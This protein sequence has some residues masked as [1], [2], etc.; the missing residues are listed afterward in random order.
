MS[1]LILCMHA[2][3]CHHLS[4][5]FS[6][7]VPTDG[8][9]QTQ[10]GLFLITPKAYAGDNKGLDIFYRWRSKFRKIQEFFVDPP[11]LEWKSFTDTRKRPNNFHRPPS[12]WSFLRV[13][14][15]T[16]LGPSDYFRRPPG[17]VPNFSYTP[18]HTSDNFHRPQYFRPITP[19]R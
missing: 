19:L 6:V 14:D 12:V 2:K 3:L 8:Q 15:W 9:I 17:R 4:S 16:A 18:L 13:I 11:Q 1:F 10:M 7:T 5:G